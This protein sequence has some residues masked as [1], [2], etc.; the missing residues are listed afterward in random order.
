MVLSRVPS[1]KIFLTKY[2]C[3]L[4]LENTTPP[5]PEDAFRL[6][7]QFKARDEKKRALP[8]TPPLPQNKT[9]RR[10][11][12]QKGAISVRRGA[13]TRARKKSTL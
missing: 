3:S 5:C 12:Q 6:P 9:N 4:E 7:I 1:Y 8:S 13:V 10:I 2:F 11:F